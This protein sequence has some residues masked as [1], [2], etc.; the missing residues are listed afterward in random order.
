M[1]KIEEEESTKSIKIDY[2]NQPEPELPI[3]FPLPKLALRHSSDSKTTSSISS[4]PQSRKVCLTSLI[5]T[6]KTNVQESRRCLTYAKDN[7]V[8]FMSQDCE[9][10]TAVSQIVNWHRRYRLEKYKTAKTHNRTVNIHA[11]PKE[12]QRYNMYCEKKIP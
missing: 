12:V 4:R 10:S 7:W 8:H 3:L 1:S 2:A 11:I 5:L 6:A 9:N